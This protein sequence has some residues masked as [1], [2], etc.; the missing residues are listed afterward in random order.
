MREALIYL[1]KYQNLRKIVSKTRNK[2][3]IIID[4][5]NDDIPDSIKKTDKREL[6]YLFDSV[7]L[8]ENRIIVF[9]TK[10]NLLHLS[11]CK[12][13]IADG[14]FRSARTISIKF[15]QY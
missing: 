13:W 6:F 14:T 8:S 15:I 11:K 12:V 2:M 9:A 10:I 4:N 7:K 1:N 3:N 5:D